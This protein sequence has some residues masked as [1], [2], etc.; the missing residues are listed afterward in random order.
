VFIFI[1]FLKSADGR[2]LLLDST[3]HLYFDSEPSH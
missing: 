3:S 2:L 1:N